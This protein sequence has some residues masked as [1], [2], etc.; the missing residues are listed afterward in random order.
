MQNY[1]TYA[2]FDSLCQNI[3][4]MSPNEIQPMVRQRI[5]ND[6][7]FQV[8]GLM[9]GTNHPFWNRTI[10][11]TVASD[12]EFLCDTVTGSG[13]LTALNATAH[14]I[15]RSTGTFAAGTL[16]GISLVTKATG[17]KVAQYLA[18]VT[19]AGATATYEII[20]SVT[21]SETTFNSSNHVLFVNCLKKLS[22]TSASLGSNYI[23]EIVKVFDDQGTDILGATG[24]ERV[25]NTDHDAKRFGNRSQD[26]L[27]ASDVFVY[28]AGDTIYFFV[29]SSATAL[30]VVQ[31]EVIIKP[32]IYTD[33]TK[34]NLLD[35]PPEENGA[36]RDSVVAEFMKAINKPVPADVAKGAAALQAKVQA[37]QADR[38]KAM[39]MKG[40]AD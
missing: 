15:T 6:F 36:L 31:A 7:I 20:G 30:G 2:E 24:K 21:G 8:Y 32:T 9:D 28:H 38:I 33:A 40:K 10:S 35:C 26:Y 16:L 3:A 18:R 13:I 25:F 19:V 27:S 37:A 5:I 11:L 39:E 34:T 1:Q 23:K 22:A 12:L 29:G 17:I 14:S 4:G